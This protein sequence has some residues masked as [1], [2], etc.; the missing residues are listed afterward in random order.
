[1][2]DQVAKPF[3]DRQLSD[4]MVSQELSALKKAVDFAECLTLQFTSSTLND[5]EEELQSLKS[6]ILESLTLLHSNYR[7]IYSEGSAVRMDFDEN[8]SSWTVSKLSAKIKAALIAQRKAAHKSWTDSCLD[9]FITRMQH[10]IAEFVR[11]EGLEPPDI[12]QWAIYAWTSAEPLLDNREFCS[13]FN[14]IIRTDDPDALKHLMP[15]VFSINRHLVTRHDVN[16]NAKW[17]RDEAGKPVRQSFRGCGIPRIRWKFFRVGRK[18]RVPGG[19]AT[20]LKQRTARKFASYASVT[21]KV[22][23][24]VR[25]NR[26][27]PDPAACMHIAFIE[28]SMVPGESEFL[29]TPF[30]KFEVIEAAEKPDHDLGNCLFLVLEAA[31]DNVGDELLPVVEWI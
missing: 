29:F 9:E 3:V 11:T 28:V 21:D 7:A 2:T 17:P 18:L 22:L 6:N 10:H 8:K 25:F 12:A 4:A 30:S 13:H 16:R 15:Y 1:V 5:A 14:E 27:C 24:E 31:I 20:S 26:H 23:I 19:F